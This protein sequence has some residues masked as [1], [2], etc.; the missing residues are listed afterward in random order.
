MIECIANPDK[1]GAGTA[2]NNFTLEKAEM[3]RNFHRSIP[4]YRETPLERL[5]A[6][7]EKCGVKDIYVKNEARRFGLNAF[8]VL[9][10]SYAVGSYI[11]D[12][13]GTDIAELS[14][15]K[16]TAPEIKRQLGTLTFISATDGNHGRGIAWMARRLGHRAV[17]LMPKGSTQERL[18]NIRSEG[19]DAWITDRNYDDTVRLANQLAEE[20]GYVMVQDTAWDGYERIPL[21]IMQGYMTMA[22]E[23]WEQ[24]GEVRP[25]HIFVQAGVGSMAGAVTGFF[26]NQYPEN[27]PVISVV[28][29]EQAACIY[30]SARAGDGKPHAVKGSLST[31]MAG[32]ACGEPNTV[33]F[34]ILWG[35]ADWFFSCPDYTAAQG[36]RILG[37]PA[38]QDVRVTAGESGAAAFGAV[39]ELLRNPD[40]RE[41]RERLGLDGN[42]VLLF[43]NTEGD[44]DKE[45]YRSIVWDGAFGRPV[46][47]KRRQTV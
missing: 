26:V 22:L 14:Y 36:M 28:E 34:Q 45:R 37:N 15:E 7:A 38:G 2:L 12:R 13:L 42:S 32:L 29:P 30:E 39:S 20:K 43:F 10:G 21:W 1:A 3:I 24:L 9:G 31:I 47:E 35:C 46:P 4:M 6:F 5:S 16:L 33:G 19:A 40:Y 11:A 23:A 44:T 17:I 41:M 25:T 18:E 27:P 8:K